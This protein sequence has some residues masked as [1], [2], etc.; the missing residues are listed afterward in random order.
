MVRNQIS[1]VLRKPSVR[2]KFLLVTLL[3][4]PWLMEQVDILVPFADSY[5]REGEVTVFVMLLHVFNYLYFYV[6]VLLVGYILLIP[7]IVRDEYTEKQSVLVSGS[8]K[9]AA[10][11]ALGRIVCFSLL[12]VMWFVFLTVV[13]SGVRIHN[14]SLEWPHF[15]D[16]VTKQVSPGSQFDMSLFMLPKG[17]TGYP[18][19]AALALVLLRSTLGFIFLGML[20]SLVTLLTKKLKYG[21]GITVFLLAVTLFLYYQFFGAYLEYYDASRPLTEVLVKVDLIKATLVPF[22]SFRSIG[23][24]FTY[25]IRYGILA[26]LGLSILAGM[27]IWIYYQKGD[28][29]NADQD[30]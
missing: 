18:V 5:G 21:V 4:I 27:G 24:D 8:R 17:C 26:G 30:E 11:T 28:L 2:I 9:K 15:V 14:F 1:M 23:D 22:F 12:Y 20:A 6:D 16:I 25:W 13:I 29:G 3:F 19:P 7:D 10:V